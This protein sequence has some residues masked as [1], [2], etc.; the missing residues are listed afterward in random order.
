MLNKFLRNFLFLAEQGDRKITAY[1][2]IVRNESIINKLGYIQISKYTKD[3][4]KFLL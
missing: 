2:Y 1:S 3:L 4:V